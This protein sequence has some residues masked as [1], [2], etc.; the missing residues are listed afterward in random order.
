MVGPTRA[1]AW[2]GRPRVRLGRGSLTLV[3]AGVWA[4]IR[5]AEDL[6]DALTDQPGLAAARSGGRPRALV[7]DLLHSV[8]RLA[9]VA[10]PRLLVLADQPH[11]PGKRVAAA[12]G[13]AGVDQGVKDLAFALPEPGHHR[14]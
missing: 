13:D 5:A 10:E 11:A 3:D 8:Q 7:P 12:P 4:P 9:Q 2:G 6:R 14:H 1:P